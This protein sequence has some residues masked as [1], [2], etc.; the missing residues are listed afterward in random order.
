LHSSFQHSTINVRL[1][2][3]LTVA[4]FFALLLW[5]L[6]ELYSYYFEAPLF[7]VGDFAAN[8]LLVLDAKH[9]TLLHGHYSRVGFFHPGPFY[10][11]AFALGETLFVDLV[12]LLASPMAAHSMTEALLASLALSLYFYVWFRYSK[13][14]L[15]SLLATAV[16]MSCLA[17]AGT[18]YLTAPWTPVMLATSMIFLLTGLMG[19]Y[20]LNA[21]WMVLALFGALQLLH[22]HASFLGLLPLMLLIIAAI[23]GLR[24]VWQRL[25]SLPAG[26]ILSGIV[27]TC[28]FLLPLALNTW[29]HWPGE[30]PKYFKQAD[31]QQHI[32][33]AD[34]LR[35]AASFLAF[36]LGGIALLYRPAR[37]ASSSA[38]DALARLSVAIFVGASASL[39][40]FVVKAID[41]TGHRYLLFWFIPAGAL[42]STAGLAHLLQLLPARAKAACSLAIGLPLAYIAA[43][44]IPVTVYNFIEGPKIEASYQQAKQLARDSGKQL[45][46]SL[47]RS[48]NPTKLWSQTLALLAKMKREEAAFVCIDAHSWDIS[49][50]DWA[51]C[52]AADSAAQLP[53]TLAYI[54][55]ADPGPLKGDGELRLTTAAAAAAPQQQ[56]AGSAP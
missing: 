50:T 26:V 54:S 9:L 35:L 55:Y 39:L 27:L 43:D 16:M 13:S 42:L 47:D 41:D 51:R 5:P 32:A 53:V 30:W 23:L 4:I 34:K 24:N 44:S 25:V 12:P 29:L 46:M 45:R 8:E 31:T 17:L 22:G 1:G 52:P 48:Q 11:Y 21:R 56:A 49:F 3:C 40:L 10:L 14:L 19:W 20:V 18:N 37:T 7:T 36:G 33:F 28:L 15:T 2:R 38:S 6:F